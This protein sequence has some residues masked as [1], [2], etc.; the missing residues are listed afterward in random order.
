MQVFGASSLQDLNLDANMNEDERLVVNGSAVQERFLNIVGELR[1]DLGA[2]PSPLF[3]TYQGR[4]D[5]VER[6]FFEMLVEDKG[7]GM[8]VTYDE[9]LARMKGGSFPR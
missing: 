7:A 9:F 8:Q 4:H 2:P 5:W 3:I 6:K 1:R